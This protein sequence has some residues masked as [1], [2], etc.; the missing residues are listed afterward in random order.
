MT[1]SIDVALVGAGTMGANHARV[2]SESQRARLV[3][4]IDAEPARAAELANA[5]DARASGDLA[6]AEHVDAVVVACPT[7]AHWDIAEHL[8]MADRPLLVEKPLAPSLDEVQ[9][10]LKISA[11]RGVPLACGFVERFNP[12][13]ATARE[14]MDEAPVHVVGM[15]HS[16]RAPR[17]STSVVQDLL[18]HDIDLALR[19]VCKPVTSVSGTLHR[20][21]DMVTDEIADC[22]IAFEDNRMAT[23]SASRVSQRKIRTWQISTAHEQIELDL[24]QQNVTVYRHVSQA[25]LVEGTHSYRAETIID[26]PF[27]RHA[28]EPL[29][30]QLDHFLD[31]VSGAADMDVERSTLL[32]PHDVAAK[33]ELAGI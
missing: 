16:P 9:R 5:H 22:L 31:L 18:I 1:A 24:L 7:E 30:L 23:L 2:I 17:I 26:I 19:L 28:G 21:A 25:L 3:C 15:R 29:A 20:P 33:V 14:M 27:V 12:V 10:M 32:A 6:D 8:L 13:I 4:V 11:V